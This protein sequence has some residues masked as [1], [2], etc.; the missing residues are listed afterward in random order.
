MSLARKG[1]KKAYTHLSGRSGTLGTFKL[2]RGYASIKRGVAIKLI[3]QRKLTRTDLRGKPL[4]AGVL[5]LVQ[6]PRAQAAD[7]GAFPMAEATKPGD[8]PD[9]DGLPNS[10]DVDDNNNGILDH[11]DPASGPPQNQ[12]TR[13]FTNLKVSLEQSLNV[14]G[15]PITDQQI[16]TLLM[17]N[18]WTTVVVSAGFYNLSPSA[19]NVNCFMLTYCRPGNGTAVIPTGQD[20]NQ[21]PAG[22]TLWTDYDP[23][24]DGFPNLV[25]IG[26]AWEMGV[27]PQCRAA[28]SH[29]QIRS[30]SA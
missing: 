14:N 10:L 30:R 11:S 6:R 26:D 28:R 21:I 12:L 20:P 16:D 3:D 25:A 8:D 13:T 4:G 1:K 7:R 22:N 17:N 5:G 2:A 15:A 29:R 27:F 24:R 9:A 23:D 19:V 18:L